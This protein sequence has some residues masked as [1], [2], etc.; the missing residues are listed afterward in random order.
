M[1]KKRKESDEF[2][3]DENLEEEVEEVSEKIEIEKLGEF[4][5]GGE[6]RDV[7]GGE[8]GFVEIAPGAAGVLS[9]GE[10]ASGAIGPVEDLEQEAGRIGEGIGEDEEEKVVSYEQ[11]YKEAVGGIYSIGDERQEQI[12]PEQIALSRKGM[13]GGIEAREVRGVPGI[14]HKDVPIIRQEGMERRHEEEFSGSGDYITGAEIEK[15][16][17][18]DSEKKKYKIR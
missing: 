4:L 18:L 12:R 8:Q 16:D 15:K 17:A 9:S 13:R 5:E 10:S 1:P 14:D 3:E 11:A 6:I 2:R 7:G